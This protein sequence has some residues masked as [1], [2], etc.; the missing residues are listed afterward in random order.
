MNKITTKTSFTVR[1]PRTARPAAVL[2]AVR[3]R[4]AAPFWDTE[5]PFY[6]N[7]PPPNRITFQPGP[8]RPGPP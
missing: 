1:A 3:F 5:R 2:P 6:V 7:L 8:F 4:P